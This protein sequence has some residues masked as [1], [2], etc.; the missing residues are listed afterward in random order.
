MKRVLFKISFANFLLTAAIFM[1]FGAIVSGSECA[2]GD[3]RHMA[4]ALTA[5]FLGLFALGPVSSYLV[6]RFQRKSVYAN[7]VLIMA[8]VSAVLYFDSG[9]AAV[10]A[11]RFVV[12][13]LC[14]V[15]QVALGSTMLNDMTVSEK[16]TNSDYNYSWSALLGIPAGAAAAYW[17]APAF[18]FNVALV[19]SIVLILLSMVTVMGIRL[20]FRAPI[21]VALFSCDRF[22]QK[23]DFLP[24]VNVLLFSSVVG[25]FLSADFSA[26][27]YL[28]MALG[29]A[30]AHPLRRMIFQNADV[31]AE[32]VAGMILVLGAELIPLATSLPASIHAANVMLGAGVGLASSRFLLYFL[33]LTGHCQ[34]GTAQNT[35]MLACGCGYAIG[36]MGGAY[37]S[38]PVCAA[39]VASVASAVFYLA[40]TH[41]WFRRHNDRDFKFHEV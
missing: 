10:A 9:L 1:Q 34:R 39:I 19:A 36:F 11:T 6:S 21:S 16:R 17:L 37:V 32:I 3:F 18:G 26:L 40:V 12:G 15:A 7:S 5:F 41:P 2:G 22:W 13:A 23:D 25:L 8:A 30:V 14:G 38:S 33:K 20:P 31:R 27:S 29:V 4:W 28:F 35:Y 24:F